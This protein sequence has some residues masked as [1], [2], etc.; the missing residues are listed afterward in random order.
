MKILTVSDVVVDLVH[1]P[2]IAERFHDID[3]IL[4]CGDLPYDYLE[5]IITMLS[6]PCYFVHGNHVQRLVTSDD[7]EPKEAPEGCVNIHRRVVNHRGL[8][9]AGLEGSMRYREGDYQYVPFEMRQMI[10]MMSPRLWLNEKRFGR[11]IDILVTH[12]PPL[13]IHDGQD[14]CHTGFKTF[15]DFMDRW[16]PLYLVH[17]HTHLYRQD[18]TRVT[19]YKNTTVLNTYGY[20]VIEIDQAVLDERAGQSRTRKPPVDA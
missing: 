3:L 4:S 7:S 10:W 5:Y 16:K 13:G 12:A 19:Q 15:L 6:K 18:A 14:L 20:Q 2:H 9:I 8:L 1:S 11:A 17:G